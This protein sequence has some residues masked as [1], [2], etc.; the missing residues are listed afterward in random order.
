[1][2]TNLPQII[3]L[4]LGRVH[5]FAD[6]PRHHS[7]VKLKKLRK[8]IEHLGQIVP[9]I[10]D[11]DGL[12]ID[13]HA[14]YAVL[15]EMGVE[16]I[17]AVVAPTRSTA[18]VKAL[19]LALNRISSEV[20]WDKVRLS[21]QLVELREL[22][23]DLELTAFDT[24]EVDSLVDFGTQ[25]RVF[26]NCCPPLPEPPVTML[27]D[28]WSLGP[29]RLAFC[30]SQAAAT[31]ASLLDGEGSAMVFC[32]LSH[33]GPPDGEVFAKSD[34]AFDEFRGL[35]DAAIEAAIHAIRSNLADGG[36]SYICAACHSVLPVL[37][38]ARSSGLD[39]LDFCVWTESNERPGV[40]YR[41]EH[42]IVIVLRNRSATSPQ[43]PRRR[44]RS[45]VWR[46]R[47]PQTFSVDHDPD[48]TE[49]TTKPIAMI[50]DAIRDVTRP[51]DT[52]FALFGAD[53]VLR[54]AEKTSR[55]CVGIECAP[56]LVDASV[57][58]WQRDTRGEAIHVQTGVP[59]SELAALRT[60][61]RA[62]GANYAA[63]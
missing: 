54:A 55:R 63:R 31:A 58:R 7:R 12:I 14:V 37:S 8:L 47:L 52:V 45:N 35:M 49:P 19:R 32:D 42:E 30:E 56:T 22:S 38:A 25:F 4:P 16:Q 62:R 27:G 5:T 60:A 13:G 34:Q 41:R 11:H 57:R 3:F 20:A 36:I 59:F 50:A 24:F 1:M 51:K 21:R 46:H 28:V 48:L 17:A 26:E 18:E 2:A 29:H 6:T 33:L 53:A 40:L 15:S 23:F 10:V 61:E 39:L 44:S 43:F 9:I